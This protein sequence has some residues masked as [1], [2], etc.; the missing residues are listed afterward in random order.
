MGIGTL[1]PSD[2]AAAAVLALVEH[3]KFTATGG[4]W[5]GAAGH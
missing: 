3:G 4:P 2:E 5:P 1:Q